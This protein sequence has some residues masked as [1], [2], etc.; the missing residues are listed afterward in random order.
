VD[1]G[2]E[3]W[4][5]QSWIQ[6]NIAT[7][8]R[9]LFSCHNLAVDHEDHFGRY[10][11]TAKFL[12]LVELSLLRLRRILTC[13][14]KHPHKVKIL[15]IDPELRRV[16]VA[17]LCANDI[18]WPSLPGVFPELREIKLQ[19]LQF[20]RHLARRQAIDVETQNQKWMIERASA[21]DLAV[22]E[23]ENFPI[24]KE[25]SVTTTYWCEV[26]AQTTRH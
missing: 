4:V 1:R 19:R 15:L 9:V 24:R 16:Q 11:A 3:L 14:T 17:H 21:V 20:R 6:L 5:E 23:D 8:V 7:N 10:P 2:P 26:D 12:I 25:D 13:G 22:F 18:D